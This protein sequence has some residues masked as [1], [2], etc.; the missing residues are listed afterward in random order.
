MIAV[1]AVLF[2]GSAVAYARYGVA[3]GIAVYVLCCAAAAATRLKG[4]R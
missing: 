4:R 1:V 3:A 2:I